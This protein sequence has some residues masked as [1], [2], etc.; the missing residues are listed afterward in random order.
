MSQKFIA[1]AILFAAWGALVVFNKAP[2]S[3][4]VTGIRDALVALGVFHVTLTNP[5]E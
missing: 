5:K 4:F 2:V 1:A 3:D